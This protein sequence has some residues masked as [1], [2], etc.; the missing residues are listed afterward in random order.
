[1]AGVQGLASRPK[2]AAAGDARRIRRLS[3]LLRLDGSD[4]EGGPGGGGDASDPAE[5][6]HRPVP[7]IV[8]DDRRYGDGGGLGEIV[9]AVPRSWGNAGADPGGDRESA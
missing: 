3:P 2:P 8:P 7:G 9:P 5:G 6:H 4:A 1:M